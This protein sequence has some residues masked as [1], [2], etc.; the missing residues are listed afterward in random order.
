MTDPTGATAVLVSAEPGVGRAVALR[1]RIEHQVHDRLSIKVNFHV[2]TGERVVLFGPSAAGKST[3]LRLIA[4]LDTPRSATIQLHDHTLFDSQSGTSTP[5]RGRRIGMV[6]Q[7]DWLFPH[8]TVEA[9]IGFGLVGQ[10]RV[11]AHS[12]IAEL[13]E[14]CGVQNLLKR[15]PRTLS[16]GE[17]QRV[18]LARALAARPR[19]LLC[20]EPFSAL[21]MAARFSLV[22]RLCQ[23]QEHER[24]PLLYVTHSPTEATRLGHRLLRLEQGAI[25]DQG[26][27]LE[28]LARSPGGMPELLNLFEGT[29]VA[30]TREGSLAL[31]V[32]QGPRLELTLQGRAV[33]DR[34]RVSIRADEIVLALGAEPPM[35]SARNV[36]RAEVQRVWIRGEQAEVALAIDQTQW[37]V[38][39]VPAAVDAL[40]LTAGRVIWMMIKSRSCHLLDEFTPP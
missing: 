3:L 26:V 34:A 30:G 1:A 33:G 29:V 24:V 8:L 21:D 9:N 18:G 19:L 12:R 6:F 11:Q 27:P 13:A 10:S 31:Q 5:L 39:I 35:V 23:V 17:R 22:D 32:D 7:D 16:G 15:R 14:L 38:A 2:L 4:G 20:D 25:V 40:G 36:L 28:V 37:L